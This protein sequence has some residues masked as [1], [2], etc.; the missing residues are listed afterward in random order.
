[1]GSQPPVVAA[2]QPCEFKWF[3]LNLCYWCAMSSCCPLAVQVVEKHWFERNRHIFP[4][5]RWE[6]FDPEKVS[7]ASGYSSL[8]RQQ[9]RCTLLWLLALYGGFKHNISL[10]LASLLLG[11]PLN[12]TMC[13]AADLQ[14]YGDK[15]T[16]KG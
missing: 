16:I 7:A 10:L 1:M 9:L 2:S 6:V 12:P 5:S 3:W 15:Y 11:P 14:D 4:A 13:C 8:H